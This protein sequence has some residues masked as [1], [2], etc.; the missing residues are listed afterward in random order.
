M[1]ARR[2][3]E[4]KQQRSLWIR[5]VFLLLAIAIGTFAYFR[6]RRKTKL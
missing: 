1:A 3:A 5:G 6:R 4:R 2:E